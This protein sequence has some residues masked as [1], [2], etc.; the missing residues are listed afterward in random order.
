MQLD[1]H[2]AA[3]DDSS[4]NVTPL[5]GWARDSSAFTLLYNEECVIT[6]TDHW[7]ECIEGS[8]LMTWSV[9]WTVWVE[10]EI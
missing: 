1:T 10:H 2:P 7:M 6:L 3:P 8:P 4:D 5:K 9:R